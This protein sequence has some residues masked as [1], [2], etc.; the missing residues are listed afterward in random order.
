MISKELSGCVDFLKGYLSGKVVCMGAKY[1]RELADIFSA[2]YVPLNNISFE[3]SRDS[4]F[5]I[6]TDLSYVPAKKLDAYISDME[7]V[8]NDNGETLFIIYKQD[9]KGLF[10]ESIGKNLPFLDHLPKI[11]SDKIYEDDFVVLFSKKLFP[12]EFKCLQCGG[13]CTHIS[14]GYQ[15]SPTPRD[16][17]RWFKNGRDD[18]ID[19]CEQCGE[20]D[21]HLEGWDAWIHPDGMDDMNRCPWKRKINGQNK[22]KC[23]INDVKPD[24]CRTW[25]P[26]SAKMAKEVKC[27]AWQKQPWPPDYVVDD[28]LEDDEF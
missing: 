4:S 8:L 23:R 9:N 15:F 19:Y 2:I 26:M 18:I 20:F 11:K 28:K 10:I 13:C 22:Y 1:G 12:N 14:G 25:I 17:A 7:P 5:M 24:H 6:L 3:T 27:A 16:M 21:N